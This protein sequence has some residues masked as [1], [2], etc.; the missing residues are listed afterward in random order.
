MT[1]TIP[2]IEESKWRHERENPTGW[3]CPRCGTINVPLIEKC[4]C[5]SGKVLSGF[6]V[7]ETMWAEPSVS[8][9]AN[10]FI[11]GNMVFEI[12]S[13]KDLEAARS[14]LERLGCP[15]TIEI[16]EQKYGKVT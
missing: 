12:Q 3:E 2:I 7:N 14:Y 10:R 15:V 13:D 4:D 11:G 8:H 9:D 16:R 1:D 5:V 6:G